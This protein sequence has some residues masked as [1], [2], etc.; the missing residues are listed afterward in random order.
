MIDRGWL[1]GAS[2]S[3]VPT[4]EGSL[5]TVCGMPSGA[6]VGRALPIMPVC[7]VCQAWIERYAREISVW[8]EQRVAKISTEYREDFLD[9]K[10]TAENER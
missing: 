9:A 2:E 1:I 4:F 7:P 5:S 6:T 10:Y 8:R 3:H